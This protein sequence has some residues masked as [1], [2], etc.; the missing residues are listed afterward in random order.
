MGGAGKGDAAARAADGALAQK[1]HEQARLRLE[2]TYDNRFLTWIGLG[3]AAI[4]AL[5]GIVLVDR[6]VMQ[7]RLE[8]C[9]LAH[10]HNCAALLDAR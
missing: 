6:L 3:V 1:A 7:N 8:D 10:R 9:I 5:G 2:K 4:L